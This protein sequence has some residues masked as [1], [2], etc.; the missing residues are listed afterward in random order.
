MLLAMI[1]GQDRSTVRNWQFSFTDGDAVVL[2]RS[3]TAKKTGL[4]IA[5]PLKLRMD[6]L[7]MTL[8]DVIARCRS[9]G[10]ISKYLIHHIRPQGDAERGDPV[11]LI[12]ISQA[13][14][15]ARTLAG[16]QGEDAPTFHEI[17]SLC[18]RTYKEQ[19]NVDTKVLLGHTSDDM[20]ALY[21]NS[22]GLTPVKVRIDAA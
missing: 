16:I 10:V 17:R 20:A 1:S 22:R 5:V 7:D 2:Q 18:S 13:F 12:S 6:A 8:G 11:R 3:K 14:A 19:G 21:E 15:K 4:R 9:T